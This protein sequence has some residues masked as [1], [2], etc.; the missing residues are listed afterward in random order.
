MTDCDWN[1]LELHATRGPRTLAL[2]LH[3]RG[4]EHARMDM[5]LDDTERLVPLQDPTGPAWG[6]E[7]MMEAAAEWARLEGTRQE[8]NP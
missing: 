3:L 4:I 2:R 1:A 7:L 5:R 6:L 8:T